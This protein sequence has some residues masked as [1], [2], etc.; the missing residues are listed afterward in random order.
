MTTDSTGMKLAL[1]SSVLCN[2]IIG[3]AWLSKVVTQWIKF[4]CNKYHFSHFPVLEQCV[5]VINGC[6]VC[7][8]WSFRLGNLD[9]DC[10]VKQ[11]AVT[12]IL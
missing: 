5:C 8:Y 1:T 10:Y 7:A 11:T 2:I 3:S 6:E 12:I 4:N 9:I